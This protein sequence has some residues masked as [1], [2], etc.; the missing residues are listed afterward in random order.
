M[1]T[2]V[3]DALRHHNDVIKWKHFLRYWPFVRGIHRSPVNSPHKGQWPRALMFSLICAWIDAWVNSREAG[4]LRRHGVHYDVIVM[5]MKW[6]YASR[7]IHT[8]T[9]IHIYI[10]RIIVILFCWDIGYYEVVKIIAAHVETDFMLY[11]LIST[12]CMYDLPHVIYACA[13]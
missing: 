3:T 8:Y 6:F 7:F 10:Y 2:K 4:D 9:H 12:T 5:E 1:L 13:W 11:Y